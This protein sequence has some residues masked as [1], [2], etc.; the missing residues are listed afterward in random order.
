MGAVDGVCPLCTRKWRRETGE[1][2]DVEEYEEVEEYVDVEEYE[3]DAEILE[4]DEEMD[5][6]RVYV[7][8]YDWAEDSGEASF[9]YT[10]PFGVSYEEG[11]SFL[12]VYESTW[13]ENHR[14]LL[15]GVE[16]IIDA[17]IEEEEVL[18]GDEF[19]LVWEWESG[20]GDARLEISVPSE[21]LSSFA[22]KFRDLYEAGWEEYHSS[23]VDDL[24]SMLTEY[25]EE[26]ERRQQEED[27][28]TMEMRYEYK[29][30][31]RTEFS[32][33]VQKGAAHLTFKVLVPDEIL[34]DYRDQ[35]FKSGR[36][37][38]FDSEEFLI[39]FWEKIENLLPDQERSSAFYDFKR[40]GL[41]MEGKLTEKLHLTWS[42]NEKHLDLGGMWFSETVDRKAYEKFPGKVE[43]YKKAWEDFSYDFYSQVDDL[44]RKEGGPLAKFDHTD[45]FE[46]TDERIWGRILFMVPPTTGE[47]LDEEYNQ[48]YRSWQKFVKALKYDLKHLGKGSKLLPLLEK[49][50]K[51]TGE[52]FEW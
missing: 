26:K 29:I 12:E 41:A 36:K 4:E 31:E 3:E 7:I 10:L 51:A 48:W 42:S 25:V 40:G 28:K 20:K 14:E 27:H 45:R 18:G 32:F 17:L 2:G 43:F 33:E 15:V 37:W 8:Q 24:D 13:N 23:L 39:S 50:K 9:S 21:I 19:L 47:E 38:T 5:I 46:V 34:E 16:K 30:E 52:S 11:Q 44:R 49:E 1:E 22:E 35:V 6:R